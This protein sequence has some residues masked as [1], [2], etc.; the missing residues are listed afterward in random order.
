MGNVNGA[1][2]PSGVSSA[3]VCAPQ[4]DVATVRNGETTLKDV[5]KRLGIPEDALRAANP[6]LNPNKLQAGQDI[7]LP[8]NSTTAEHAR[9]NQQPGGSTGDSKPAKDGV[10]IPK[11]RVGD[12]DIPLPKPTLSTDDGYDRGGTS[13]S[14][15][16]EQGRTD[17]VRNT[18]DRDVDP[19]VSDQDHKKKIDQ[20]S[21]EVGRQVDEGFKNAPENKMNRDEE[22]ERKDKMIKDMSRR[23]N[24]RG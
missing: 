17:S 7:C 6:K 14:S 12:Y 19:K 20:S 2:G 18:D 15:K 4:E 10:K 9:P 5:S 8:K 22:K 21:K 13:S 16:V 23:L 1:G 11:G 24:I 3:N